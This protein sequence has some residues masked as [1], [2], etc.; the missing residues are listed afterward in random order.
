MEKQLEDFIIQN[1]EKTELGKKYDL[2]VRILEV[3]A[4]VR[5]LFMHYPN[6]KCYR[7]E[8]SLKNRSVW[9]LCTPRTTAN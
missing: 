8:L 1:W 6:P 4:R 3:Q 5:K 2:D 7:L 9:K